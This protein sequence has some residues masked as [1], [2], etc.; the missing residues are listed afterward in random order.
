M[1]TVLVTGANRGLGFEFAK[2]YVA[3]G[4]RIFAACR[5]S[6]NATALRAMAPTAGNMISV[7][8]MDVTDTDSVRAAASALKDAADRPAHQLRGNY[9]GRGANHRPR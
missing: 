6:A 7:V 1:L 9:R 8:S 2:Q 5:N 3:E 4:W